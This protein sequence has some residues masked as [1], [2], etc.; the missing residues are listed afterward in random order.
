MNLNNSTLS[1]ILLTVGAVDFEKK[2]TVRVRLL[3]LVTYQKKSK[4][5]ALIKLR[6]FINIC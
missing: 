1:P 5:K 2:K 6:I 3:S 4:V